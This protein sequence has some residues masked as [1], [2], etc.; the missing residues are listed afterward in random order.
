LTAL[1]IVVI[2]VRF[3]ARQP[4]PYADVSV[5]QASSQRP[6][7]EKSIKTA[8]YALTLTE[9][10]GLV[11]PPDRR[12]AGGALEPLDDG[13]L[14]VTAAGEFYQLSW[15]RGGNALRARQL[16]LSVPFN[17]N[18]ILE[19]SGKDA[20]NPFRILDLHVEERA[21]TRR[22]YVAHHH[23]DEEGHCVTLRVS[24]APLPAA[25]ASSRTAVAWD[26]LF[27]SKPCLVVG[28]MWP[29]G[30]QADRS[31]G[32]LARHELGLLL[33][34]GD[35]GFDGL[36]GVESFSQ[37]SDANYGKVLLL[38]GAGGA[39]PFSIGHRNAQG[40]AVDGTG[41]IWATEHGPQGGDELNLIV[42]GANYG[43]PTVTYGTEYEG[44]TWPHSPD[45]RSHGEFHEPA[46]AF[47][48][49]IGASQVI[50]VRSKY[51]PRWSGDLL[52]GSLQAG[53][54]FRIR[55]SGDRVI[56]TEPINISMRI[57]D[58]AEGRDGRMLIW[59]DDGQ[60]V[61]VTRAQPPST[62]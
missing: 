43:W 58:I 3:P 36:D 33:T 6:E 5:A 22:V 35:Y 21:G 1:A 7:T 19:Q 41:R 52:L 2:A 11:P 47:V 32:R 13:F 10:P 44:D 26:R 17:R 53:T 12:R 14:L 54:L 29:M 51:L 24:S 46:L 38:D 45:A 34:V 50:Q 4:V 55:T 16:P 42:R 49:S 18:T 39:V 37:A 60:V 30:E 8:N 23:F 27:D 15:Q 62:P 40:L 48:P 31:G 9:H 59:N 25:T 56:Y 61:S 20:A 28:K 57:R